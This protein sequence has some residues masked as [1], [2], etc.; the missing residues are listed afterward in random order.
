MNV[1]FEINPSEADAKVI[2]DGL[3]AYNKPYFGYENLIE[4]ACFARDA[5]GKILG[6]ATGEIAD[7]LAFI[8]LLWV[9]EDSRGGAGRQIM[10]HMETELKTRK[11][12][13]IHLDTYSFQAPEFYKK[14]GF[15]EVSRF[16]VNKPRN[17][18]KVF[19][20]KEL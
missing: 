6:G 14:L 11:V 12:T 7:E 13:E 3:V 17:I 20:I 9:D 10:Q 18:E 1:D 2:L 5:D 19:F 15:K 16:T 4:F 8:W